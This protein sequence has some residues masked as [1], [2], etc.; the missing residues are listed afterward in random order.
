MIAQ[1]FR[2]NAGIIRFSGQTFPVAA[3]ATTGQL[4]DRHGNA[5][6][7]ATV[8]ALHRTDW[9][10]RVALSDQPRTNYAL[11][12]QDFT[13]AAW[14][15]T[16]N[17]C[18]FATGIAGPTGGT[19]AQHVAADTSNYPHGVR[20]QYTVGSGI[21]RHVVRAKASEVPKLAMWAFGLSATIQQ[22]ATALFDLVAGTVAAA[23][24]VNASISAEAN[25]Y[26]LCAMDVGGAAAGTLY[27]HAG[28][29]GPAMVGGKVAGQYYTGDGTSGVDMFCGELYEVGSQGVYIPTTTAPVTVTDYVDNGDGTVGLGQSA[30]SGDVYDFDG[31]SKR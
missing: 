6:S 17:H 29:A 25:G 20:Q 26:W 30:A 15:A 16:N 5:L 22:E 19:N 3:G 31:V 12:S 28:P 9:Q 27:T 4:V 11:Y 14:N 23:A 1:S 10:G 7:N 24:S 21:Y 8:K 18:V 2:Y 13:N